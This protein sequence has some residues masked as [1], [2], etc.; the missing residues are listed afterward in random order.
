MLAVPVGHFQ[1]KKQWRYG[2]EIH[3]PVV[4]VE[5]MSVHEDHPGMYVM[6][7]ENQHVLPGNMD[8][9]GTSNRK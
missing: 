9:P 7:E 1:M 6:R 4:T 2:P 5:S 8:I 3:L